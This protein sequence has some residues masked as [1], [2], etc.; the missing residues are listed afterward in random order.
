MPDESG[1]HAPSTLRP[2]RT[3]RPVR[4]RP[5][6]PA[7]EPLPERVPGF[8]QPLIEIV[9]AWIGQ[10]TEARRVGGLYAFEIEVS[11]VA[12][13]LHVLDTA[14]GLTDAQSD[15]E[16]DLIG[17]VVKEL[18]RRRTPDTLAV[19]E[20]LGRI[21]VGRLRGLAG[22]AAQ[23]LRDAGVAPPDWLAELDEPCLLVEC[24]EL[25]TTRS[26]D[27]LL[28][29]SFERDGQ[30][31]GFAVVA[32]D[33]ECGEANSIFAIDSD[34]VELARGF[35]KVAKELLITRTRS[36][37]T[38]LS[39]A[40]A[41]WRIATALAR[42][43]DHDAE[44]SPDE[45]I[46]ALIADNEYEDPDGQPGPTFPHLFPLL[47]SKLELLPP[48]GRPLPPH[49]EPRR[50]AMADIQL[51]LRDALGRR[52]IGGVPIEELDGDDFSFG[53]G[54]GGH[55]ERPQSTLPGKRAEKDGPAPVY[56]LRIDLRGAKPPIWRRLEVHADISLETMH[57]LI[58]S[59]FDWED[60]HLYVF[61]TAYGRYGTGD[62]DLGHRHS[63]SVALEQI[64]RQEGEKLEY[65]Y[66]F[67]DAWEH[68]IKLEKVLPPEPGL[69]PRCTAGRR[70]APPEDSG[71]IWTYEE[72]ALPG[73][74]HFDKDAMNEILRERFGGGTG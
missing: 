57:A 23:G 52:T 68:L 12:G 50:A 25:R 14:L 47:T 20:A 54:G 5:A 16:D 63:A 65:M 24:G 45:L 39:P 10:L 66:D 48:P 30:W 49:V 32:D 34:E 62:E 28:L 26:S 59:L 9:D 42:R 70:N 8:E 6:P 51:I 55:R 73:S 53:F 37:Y 33:D 31:Q 18:E 46:S 61:E 2:A 67:G 71:G 44:L 4:R 7:P 21:A 27:R 22:A 60:C 13:T 64:L 15:G 36:T 11:G 40:E 58:Q 74:D 69:I 19:L 29:L 17:P 56:R 3:T 41:H 1:D 35:A 72:D 43:A 38:E